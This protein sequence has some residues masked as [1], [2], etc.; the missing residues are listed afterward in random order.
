[1]IFIIAAFSAVDDCLEFAHR[2]SQSI[3]RE[4][5]M[6]PKLHY[7]FD[8]LCGWCYAASPL[9]AR[10][11]ERFGD[12]LELV[13]H[14]GLLFAQPHEIDRAYREHIIG[15][16]QR[17]AALTGVE[18]GAPYIE[19]VR[20]APVLRYHSELPAAAVVAVMSLQPALG[21]PM[22][23]AIQ[24]SHYVHGADVGDAATLSALAQSLGLAP[25]AFEPALERSRRSLLPGLA[26]AARRLSQAVGGNGFPTLVLER[27]GQ[28]QKLDHGSAYGK[29][30]LLADRVELLIGSH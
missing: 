5:T 13:F 4:K 24:R 28:Y 25:Q 12:R 21:L 8:P 6:K 2:I 20:T 29:P 26:E 27:D 14:P 18:F 9:L 16:D 23:E 30:E 1:M 7:L 19:R 11:S 3:E 22:L 17:I 15:A 10:L